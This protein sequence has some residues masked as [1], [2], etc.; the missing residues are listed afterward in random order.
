MKEIKFLG[1]LE[2]LSFLP[3]KDKEKTLVYSR[4]EMPAG[5]RQGGAPPSKDEVVRVSLSQE[6]KDF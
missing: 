3:R 2:L 1:K 4:E 5:G 6:F